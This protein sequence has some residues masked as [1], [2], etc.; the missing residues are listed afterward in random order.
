MS[1][2]VFNGT[3]GTA[4]NGTTNSIPYDIGSIF[5]LSNIILFLVF[6]V[7]ALIIYSVLNYAFNTMFMKNKSHKLLKYIKTRRVFSEL[8]KEISKSKSSIFSAIYVYSAVIFL[9]FILIG[10]LFVYATAMPFYFIFG[11][12][13]I[14]TKS[15]FNLSEFMLIYS[16]LLNVLFFT[17]FTLFRFYSPNKN[18]E[19][20]E[21]FDPLET[22]ILKKIG[23]FIGSTLSCYFV[24]YSYSYYTYSHYLL[25]DSSKEG[26]Y[27]VLNFLEIIYTNQNYFAY[28]TIFYLPCLLV[29]LVFL[30]KTYLKIIEFIVKLRQFTFRSYIGE[31]P[32]M[33]IRTSSKAYECEIVDIDNDFITLSDKGTLNVIS[34][35]SIDSLEIEEL[36]NPIFKSILENKPNNNSVKIDLIWLIFYS[37]HLCV[38]FFAPFIFF[39]LSMAENKKSINS[40][41]YLFYFLLAIFYIAIFIYFVPFLIAIIEYLRSKN[42]E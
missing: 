31:L 34:W 12:F 7:F 15:T 11:I 1:S 16:A 22:P 5:S 36:E 3:N 35:D 28:F 41:D 21:K 17:P 27:K 20:K 39:L 2:L 37:T 32:H 8:Y 4:L 9:T 19:I 24:V 14:I 13:L 26:I 42:P 33:Y 25:L 30:Y 6:P 10:F 38:I 29:S 23:V 18:I 40:T